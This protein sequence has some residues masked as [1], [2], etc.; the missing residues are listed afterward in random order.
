MG[1]KVVKKVFNFLD[2]FWDS[3]QGSISLTSW[4]T[5]IFTIRLQPVSQLRRRCCRILGVSIPNML[6]AGYSRWKW[7]RLLLWDSRNKKFGVGKRAK[8]TFGRNQVRI[9]VMLSGHHILMSRRSRIGGKKRDQYRHLAQKLIRKWLLW[10]QRSG[11]DNIKMDFTKMTEVLFGLLVL[12]YTGLFIS[13]SGIS[14]LD[15]AKTKTD[16]AER[17][18]LIGRESLQ[19]FFCTRGL[20]E[21]RGSTVRG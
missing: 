6:Q 1:F 11:L 5:I 19:V 16:T 2:L 9:S 17:S 21:L 13:P 3:I 10:I 8:L 18:I 15:C 4:S 7:M 14:E 12:M 20:V